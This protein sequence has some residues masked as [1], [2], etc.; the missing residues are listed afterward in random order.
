[1]HTVSV[2]L[3]EHLDCRLTALAKKRRTS[4]AQVLRDALEALAK[5]S[6][7]TASDL[8]GDLIGS[9]DGPGDLSSNPKYMAGYGR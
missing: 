9:V 8:A 4:R 3:P 6:K 1:M 5:R 7:L 2:R